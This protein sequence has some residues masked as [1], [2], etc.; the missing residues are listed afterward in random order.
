MPLQ[1]TLWM[2]IDGGGTRSRF[3]VA[4]ASGTV[5]GFT[6]GGPLNINNIAKAEIAATLR[7]AWA[8]LSAETAIEGRHFHLY[9]GVAGIKA[10][11]DPAFFEEIACAALGPA[12]LTVAAVNDTDIT[13]AGGLLGEPG[14]ALILGTGS[15]CLGRNQQGETRTCGGWGYLMDDCGSAYAIGLAG[16]RLATRTWDGRRHA[17]RLA[18]SIRDSLGIAKAEHVL[19]RVYNQDLGHAGIKELA[20][21][22]VANAQDGD[23][24]A[25]DILHTAVSE[26]AEMVEVLGHN[27]HLGVGTQIVLTGAIAL[28]PFINPMLAG[29]IF[30][31]C[32]GYRIA[33]QGLPP[34]AG[35][36]LRARQQAGEALDESFLQHL[37]HSL[38]PYLDQL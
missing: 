19:K 22:V 35:A 18:A 21:V 24:D 1:E 8:I 31:R 2:G 28:H 3:V 9:A 15:H 16:L 29:A 27:L 14:I 13:L 38:H 34:V 20:R 33:A 11:E 23:A 12:C 36:V 6:T 10:E 32:P 25:R 26:A 37:D 4:D 30:R 5:V 17:Y 7:E